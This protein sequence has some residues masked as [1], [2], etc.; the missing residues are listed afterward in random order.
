M[1]AKPFNFFAGVVGE[2][3]EIGP[4]RIRLRDVDLQNQLT[5]MFTEQAEAFLSDE[6]ERIEYDS[7]ANYRL[8]R[9]QIF[10]IKK[11]GLP[12]RIAEAALRPH[13]SPD[14]RLTEVQSRI[15]TVFAADA[16]AK[17]V[18][19]VLFQQF[20]TPQLLDKRFSLFWSQN[21]FQRVSSDGLSLAHELAAIFQND[22]LY[23][24]SFAIVRRF[25]DLEAF[26]P[27]ATIEEIASF[28]KHDLFTID[29]E[30]ELFRIIESDSWLR[31][32]IASIH[33]SEILQLVKPKQARSKAKEFGI[34]IE[35]AD[36]DGRDTIQLPQQKKQLKSVVKFLNEEFFHGEL[37]SK[38]YE[39][40]SHRSVRK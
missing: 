25:L 3:D 7:K 35:I 15:A 2:S 4:Q 34:D 12:P 30:T 40:N 24:R 37:T 36:S 5:T 39:T 19:R 20:R 29:N 10:V 14:F 1:Q 16:T 23:F 27:E 26:E 13:E 9:E 18:S 38:L 32:R 21:A 8:E 6:F 17:A 33:S 22:N 31:R 11:L 28:V